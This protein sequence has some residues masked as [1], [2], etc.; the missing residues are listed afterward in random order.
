MTW[1]VA[2]F[3]I[4]FYITGQFWRCRLKVLNTYFWTHRFSKIIKLR[5]SG[6]AAILIL[7]YVR[8]DNWAYLKN[9]ARGCIPLNPFCWSK[10]AEHEITLAS[11]T[12]DPAWLQTLCFAKM[13]TIVAGRGTES[14]KGNFLVPT[15]GVT[16]GKPQGAQGPPSWLGLTKA[17]KLAST[18][19]E[20]RRNAYSS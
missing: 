11:F 15:S 12:A 4:L 1:K 2:A 8:Y 6:F 3:E 13:C 20:P 10:S 19:I 17:S 9:C 16:F 14:F 7:R 5:D 18:G